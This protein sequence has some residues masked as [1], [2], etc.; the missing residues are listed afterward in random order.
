MNVDEFF[1]EFLE[2]EKQQIIDAYIEGH[3]TMQGAGCS[4]TYYT[5]TFE[6]NKETLK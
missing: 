6:T 5:S 4:N 3:T 2:T 1:V